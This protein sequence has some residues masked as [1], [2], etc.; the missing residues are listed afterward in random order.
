[1]EDVGLVRRGWRESEIR[2]WVGVHWN[3]YPG[4]QWRGGQ[5]WEYGS[6]ISLA[7]KEY[8]EAIMRNE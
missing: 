2:L 4:A 8:R 1:M 6:G 3:G 7:C 5:L